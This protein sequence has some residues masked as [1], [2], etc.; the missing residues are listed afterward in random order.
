MLKILI[1]GK[2]QFQNNYL[3]YLSKMVFHNNKYTD[4]GLFTPAW[5]SKNLHKALNA[6]AKLADPQKLEKA[7]TTAADWRVRE[8]AVKKITDNVTLISIIENENEKSV[9]RA[10]VFN[11]TDQNYLAGLLKGYNSA[12]KV[13]WANFANISDNEILFN[14][15]C[16]PLVYPFL[17]LDQ[18]S[19]IIDKLDRLHLNRLEENF[20]ITKGD[21]DHYYRIIILIARKRGN[22]QKE[23]LSICCMTDNNRDDRRKAFSELKYQAAFKDIIMVAQ[24]RVARIHHYDSRRLSD[25]EKIAEFAIP[26]FDKIID[27]ELICKIILDIPYYASL[28]GSYQDKLI[29]CYF[30]LIDKVT[31][32]QLL[33][34]IAKQGHEVFGI[35]AV[36][37]ITDRDKLIKLTTHLPTHSYEDVRESYNE[38]TSETINIYYKRV[39]EKAKLKLLQ[40]DVKEYKK[41]EIETQPEN[42]VHEE[43]ENDNVT[44][45]KSEKLI[46]VTDISQTDILSVKQPEAS[47]NLAKQ[48]EVVPVIKIGRKC[49]C[50]GKTMNK[51]DKEQPLVSN[52]KGLTICLKCRNVKEQSFHE[53]QGHIL[54]YRKEKSGEE[55]QRCLLCGKLSRFTVYGD[56]EGDKFFQNTTCEKAINK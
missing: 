44:V 32:E 38:V 13:R 26:S 50:C 4:M 5:K 18:L 1:Y 31:N 20:K 21:N 46:E 54:I 3:I 11:V 23:L 33:F 14:A 12:E 53:K 25:Y 47:A 34:R 7:A 42:S 41:T 48:P 8:A 24:K 6:I 40:M 10:A 56:I 43:T 17:G 19:N 39:S 45:P 51:K 15:I 16:H 52:G 2:E 27:Q 37:R 49:L 36:D 29:D 55:N 35:R 9:V 28:R 22:L 30:S